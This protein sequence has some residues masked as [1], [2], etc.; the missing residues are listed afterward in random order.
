MYDF[1]CFSILFAIEPHAG[2]VGTMVLQLLERKGEREREQT[3]TH[4][5]CSIFDVLR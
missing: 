2:N 5:N 1:I 4:V 3:L